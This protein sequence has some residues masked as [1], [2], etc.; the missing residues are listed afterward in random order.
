MHTYKVSKSE[1]FTEPYPY[2]VKDNFLSANLIDEIKFNWPDD[3]YFYDEIAGIRLV[4]LMYSAKAKKIITTMAH[5]LTGNISF[6]K[7]RK[8]LPKIK[9]QFWADFVDFEIPKIN[10]SIYECFEKQLSEKFGIKN[11]VPSI[12]MANLMQA[13]NKFDGH[14]IHTHHYHNPNW[15]YTVLLYVDD[16]GLETKGTDLYGITK[17][18]NLSKLDAATDFSIKHRIVVNPEGLLEN[19]KTVPF[20]NNRLFAFLDTP[21][22]YHGVTHGKVNDDTGDNKPRR[23]IIRLHTKYHSSYVKKIYGYNLNEYS[24]IRSRFTENKT[25][26]KIF[27]LEDPNHLINKGIK[28][29]LNA[30]FNL[31]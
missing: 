31:K 19:K 21:I 1:L 26:N 2:I 9:K 25:P 10:N 8:F 17:K 15:T 22:S 28:K 18:T 23:K 24:K 7:N 16:L 5:I 27:N 12:E 29:E 13:N 4:D 20:K 3:D 11:S 30:I 14:G 6:L